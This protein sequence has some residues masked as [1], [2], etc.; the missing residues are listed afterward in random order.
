MRESDGA[1]ED[2]EFLLAIG[3]GGGGRESVSAV[4]CEAEIDLF[5]FVDESFE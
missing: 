2:V 5:V 1:D 4:G 3:N